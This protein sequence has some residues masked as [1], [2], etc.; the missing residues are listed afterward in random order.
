MRIEK[1]EK[2]IHC[3]KRK[4]NLIITIIMQEILS[5]KGIRTII[6]FKNIL[7]KNVTAILKIAFY[8]LA[9]TIRYFKYRIERKDN[10]V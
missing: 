10:N 7:F 3:E 5:E 1:I 8:V 4:F 2:E 9:G 6:L